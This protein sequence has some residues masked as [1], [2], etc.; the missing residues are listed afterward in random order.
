ME[1]P[2][3]SAGSQPNTASL[4]PEKINPGDIPYY[5]TTR[6]LDLLVHE[7]KTFDE[8]WEHAEKRIRDST[9]DNGCK[10][11]LRKGIKT[12]LDYLAE[13]SQSN[14][15]FRATC[16]LSNVRMKYMTPQ[17]PSILNQMTLMNLKVIDF[18]LDSCREPEDTTN[19]STYTLPASPEPQYGLGN[20]TITDFREY[21]EKSFR[22][23]HL[24][25][26]GVSQRLLEATNQSPAVQNQPP[27]ALALTNDQPPAAQNP[28]QP[29]KALAVTDDPVVKQ[30]EEIVAGYEMERVKFTFLG[31][32]GRLAMC[33][34][35]WCLVSP[36]F[37]WGPWTDHRS[38]PVG[39]EAIN[40]KAIRWIF[41]NRRME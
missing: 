33:L 28:L 41:K 30:L 39:S 37:C 1:S 32:Y 9:L 16:G 24:A 35:I 18:L 3:S 4:K 27:K 36:M 13:V 20:R 11:L 19:L 38:I 5:K 40:K 23:Y 7:K 15:E 31:D 21:N 26:Q 34:R 6:F 29:P 25:L 8:L 14:G 10:E 17:Q 2:I 22:T 12:H